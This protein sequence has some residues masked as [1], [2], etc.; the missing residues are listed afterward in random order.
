MLARSYSTTGGRAMRGLFGAAAV[1]AGLAAGATAQEAVTYKHYAYR[2]GDTTRVVKTEET[3][4]VTTLGV[5]GFDQK[6][7]ETKKKTV[8]YTA[9]V[10]EVGPD[11]TK[12]AKVRRTYEKAV[13]AKDGTESPLPLAGKTVV[14]EKTGEKYAFALA[15]GTAPTE[16]EAADL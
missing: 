5:M 10:L 12:P 1:L 14:I 16:K 4:T 3:T 9:E 6:K 7:D 15:D 2:A 8:V 11:A 13:E